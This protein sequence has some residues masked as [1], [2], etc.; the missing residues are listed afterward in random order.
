M[1]KV[2][3][4]LL[5]DLSTDDQLDVDE[6]TDAWED[7]LFAFKS[8]VLNRPLIKKL[9]ISQLSKLRNQYIAFCY[10]M[11]SS[12]EEATANFQPRSLEVG[13]FPDD[14]SKAFNMY[15]QK[16]N[17]FKLS[18]HNAH[19]F[20]EIIETLNQWYAMEHSFQSY[21]KYIHWDEIKEE[22]VVSKEPDPMEVMKAM[23][24][25]K[26]TNQEPLRFS[27][28]NNHLVKLPALLKSE[29]KRLTL[30]YKM[31]EKDGQ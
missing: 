22:V 18:L 11:E 14:I 29:G 16:K 28:L 24:S 21:W 19:S 6:V 3:A 27:S 17:N 2:N 13:S 23:D 7:K 10:L 5:L 8:K 12:Y 26:Q 4:K 31:N 1:N 9:L 30:L 20:A 25:F 15:F